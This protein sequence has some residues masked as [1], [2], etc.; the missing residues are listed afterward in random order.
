L[1]HAEQYT[2]W[3]KETECD[4]GKAEVRKGRQRVEELVGRA[5]VMPFSFMPA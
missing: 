2:R 1:I 4:S 3:A 5:A